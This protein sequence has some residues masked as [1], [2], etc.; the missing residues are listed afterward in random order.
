[1]KA[2]ADSLESSITAAASSP[3]AETLAAVAADVKVVGSTIRS[4]GDAL[5]DT[6]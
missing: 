5:A 1:M 6:C 4:L 3:S 2:A